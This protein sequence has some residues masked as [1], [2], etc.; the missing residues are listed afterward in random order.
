MQS[1]VNVV[2]AVPLSLC[3]CIRELQ[4]VGAASI[5]WALAMGGVI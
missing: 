2:R 1:L 3:V 5:F 4:F